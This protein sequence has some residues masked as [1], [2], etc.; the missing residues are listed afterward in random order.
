MTEKNKRNELNI[1]ELNEVAGGA[2]IEVYEKDDCYLNENEDTIYLIKEDC[3]AASDIGY[4]YC[5]IYRKEG[6]ICTFIGSHSVDATTL[7]SC[8]M[9][10]GRWK[11]PYTFIKN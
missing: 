9:I 8:N 2:Y 3:Q 7:A 1:T 6:S 5:D 10:G 4:V 11:L